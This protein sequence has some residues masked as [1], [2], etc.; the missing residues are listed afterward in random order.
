MHTYSAKKRVLAVAFA[1]VTGATLMSGPADADPK[2]LNA[3]VGVGSDTTQDVL[4][5]MAGFSNGI[6]YTPVQS[7]TGTGQRQVISFDATPPPGVADSCIAPKIGGPTFNRPNGSSGGRRALSRAMDGTGYGNASC[8]GVTDVTGMIDFAR[9]SAGP[10]SGD[11]GTA[12]TYVPFGRDGVSFAYFRA[13]GGA[14]VVD[15]TRAQLT[16]LFTTGPQV[17]G[18]V[19][20]IPCGIQT[21]SGTFAFWNS[22]T[23]A[24]TSQENSATTECNNL[25]GSG[26]MQENDGPALAAK[27]ALAP[28]GDQVIVGF[29]AGAFISK[30]NGRAEP[31]PGAGVGIG[32]IS[33]NGSGTNLGSPI[34]GTAPNLTP[35]SAFFS[36]SVFGRTV[37][38]VL[39]TTLVTSP[40]NND[41]K[42]I[43]IG[44]GSA[45]CNATTVI[46][47]FGFLPAANC[48][49]TTITG[50]LL[51]GQL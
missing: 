45:V 3:A 8:G 5:A 11:T 36:D 41:I 35:N 21:S 1:A 4:N 50:S 19:R 51:A 34:S 27:G 48:G 10:A 25:G 24:T 2:Q 16:S 15:L 43:F 28:A 22:V 39:P 38:N 9:S 40:G 44:S 37:Y 26:R 46:Q 31:N 17:I 20:I 7:S 18:G 23:T 47:Q 30:S 32:S 12:L 13:S 14:P 49:V 33:N 42:N 6:N 29:S